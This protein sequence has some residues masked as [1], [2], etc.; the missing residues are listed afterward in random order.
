MSKCENCKKYDDCR[1]G[2]GLTWPCGA[3]RPRIGEL[4]PEEV[5]ELAKAKAEG[6]LVVLPCK[7]EWLPHTNVTVKCSVC[8]G[9]YARYNYCPNCGARMDGE[10]AEKA[11]EGGG[12]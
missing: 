7:G 2:S 5:H 3:Y 8:G 10:A 4:S 1:D 6:R 12:K 9:V 11:L